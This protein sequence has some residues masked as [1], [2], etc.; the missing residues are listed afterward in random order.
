[1]DPYSKEY[2]SMNSRITKASNKLFP[3]ANQ[4]SYRELW[5]DTCLNKWLDDPTQTPD[6]QAAR[7]S[8]NYKQTYAKRPPNL[9]Y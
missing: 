3:Y 4:K 6:V 8:P 9:G 7:R 1:M 5:E 2:M